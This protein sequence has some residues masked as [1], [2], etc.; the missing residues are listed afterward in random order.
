[1]TLEASSRQ[2]FA[3][4]VDTYWNELCFNLE[5]QRRVYFEALGCIDMVV[6]ENEGDRQHGIKRKL[7]F[8]K[9]IDAP[10]PIAK[11][12]GG[13]VT[14]EE[15]GVFDA[16]EQCWSFRMVP[17]ILGDRIDI[18]GRVHAVAHDGGT[19][20]RSVNSVT[21]KMFGLGAIIEPFVM[22]SGEEGIA[23]KLA[24][25]KRYITEKNLR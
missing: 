22:R 1:M 18:R 7:R 5:Y 16:H 17:S 2:Q 12:F 4:S 9:P 25:T 3:V 19:L 6:L 11:I 10:G 14:L 13:H 24:F 23:D 8:I 20:Q 21:C 15:H